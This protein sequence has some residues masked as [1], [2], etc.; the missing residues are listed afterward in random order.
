MIPGLAAGSLALVLVSALAWAGF[1]LLRKLLAREIGPL[2]LMALLCLASAPP[3]ALWATLQGGFSV[4]PG[5]WAPALGSVM[6]NVAANLLFLEALRTGELS[7]AVP[8]L[9]LSPAFAALVAIPLL[10]EHPTAIDGCGIALVVVGAFVLQTPVDTERWTWR[11]MLAHRGLRLMAGTALLWSLTIPLDKLAVNRSHPP[12][13]A[14]VLNLGVAIAALALLA[15]RRQLHRLAELR[16]APLLFLAALAVSAVALG[17]QLAALQTV[18]VSIVETLKRTIGNL[19]AVAVG[20]LA[21]GEAVTRRKLAAVVLMA[22]GV[23][24]IL[25]L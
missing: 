4:E 12:L 14:L 3:F 16:R 8:L 10:G 11:W 18:W 13:H 15:Q 19:S 7:I 22:G 5:Y 2:P 25:L 23:A 24:L 17:A 21:F 1:D 9:S 20:R 6:L